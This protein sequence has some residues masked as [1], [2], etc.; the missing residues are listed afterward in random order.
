MKR[1]HTDSQNRAYQACGNAGRYIQWVRVRGGT[2][3]LGSDNY[4]ADRNRV[5]N[6]KS[7]LQTILQ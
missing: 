1:S 4:P 5:S 6:G 2:T 3:S 7:F